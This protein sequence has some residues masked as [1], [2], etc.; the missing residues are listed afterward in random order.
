MRGMI[1]RSTLDKNIPSSLALGSASGTWEEPPEVAACSENQPHFAFAMWIQELIAVQHDADLVVEIAVHYLHAQMI[2]RLM[3]PGTAAT[4][5]LI[6]TTLIPG[7]PAIDAFGR[8]ECQ[9]G[10]HQSLLRVEKEEAGSKHF[11]KQ[12]LDSLHEK[13]EGQEDKNNLN[14]DMSSVQ[15]R[16]KNQR[17]DLERT[18][19]HSPT[20]ST[21]ICL[22]ERK[23]S[24]K[25]AGDG[26]P[27]VVEPN[28]EETDP[29]SSDL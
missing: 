4:M 11:N 9:Q 2:Q 6:G 10:Q 3:G 14:H 22:L 5:V 20:C 1:S 27:S 28:P 7:S 8:L 24:A 26:S 21:I 19:R 15:T 29:I 17:H 23:T 16:T 25:D 12:Q 18:C 13:K